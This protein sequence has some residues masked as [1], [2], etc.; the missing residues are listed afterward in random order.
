[1]PSRGGIRPGNPTPAHAAGQG[2]PAPI[3]P[4]NPTPVHAGKTVGGRPSMY[5]WKKH[6]YQKQNLLFTFY[7]VIR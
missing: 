2:S 1:M 6:C 7:I 5:Y 3:R 4:D